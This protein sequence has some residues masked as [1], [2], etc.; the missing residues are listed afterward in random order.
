VRYLCQ[1]TI[2]MYLGAIVEDAPTEA[3]IN[4]PLHPYARAL[5]A[6]VPTPDPAQNR[7][8]LPIGNTPPDARA[9]T[10]GCRFADRCPNVMAKCRSID[11]PA[12]AMGGGHSVAC[13]LYGD[14][15]AKR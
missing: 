2:V 12:I 11:P 3:I 4:A 1:R 13:H 8:A 7:G 15:A 6:A 9:L 10:V 14:G 5:V